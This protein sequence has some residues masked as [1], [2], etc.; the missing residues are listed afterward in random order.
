MSAP[1]VDSAR[2]D[3]LRSSCQDCGFHCQRYGGPFS[4]W[5]TLTC[6]KCKVKLCNVSIEEG[7]RLA[8]F[9]RYHQVNR[10]DHG[11]DTHVKSAQKE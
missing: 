10:Y 9:M 7:L 1:T 4:I 3:E 8:D 2:E 5:Y 6:K 11:V